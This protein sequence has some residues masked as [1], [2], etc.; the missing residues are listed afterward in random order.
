MIDGYLPPLPWW[1]WLIWPGISGMLGLATLLEYKI[2]LQV[3]FTAGVMLGWAIFGG[4]FGMTD[5]TWAVLVGTYGLI[6]FLTSIIYE[7]EIVR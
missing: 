1:F 6:L 4:I 5:I 3:T 7:E 2:G